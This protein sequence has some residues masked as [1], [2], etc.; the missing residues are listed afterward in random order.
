[1]EW[2]GVTGQELSKRATRRELLAVQDSQGCVYYPYRQ[3]R[4]D[5]SVVPGLRQVLDTLAT[6]TP[7]LWTWAL[8]LAG[9]SDALSGRTAWEALLDGDFDRVLQLAE[10]DANRWSE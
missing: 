3:F 4:E 6:G 10:G 2:L 5:G 1:M 7:V 9:C 8:W